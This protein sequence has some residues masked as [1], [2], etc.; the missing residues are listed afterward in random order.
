MH[1]H[2]LRQRAKMVAAIASAGQPHAI[3]GGGGKGAKHLQGD[4]L[5]A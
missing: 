3:A 2:P 1:L 5:L 4:R